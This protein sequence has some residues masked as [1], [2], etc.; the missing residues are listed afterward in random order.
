MLRSDLCDYSD[1]YVVVKELLKTINVEEDNKIGK[2][3]RSLLFKDNLPFICRISK[4]NNVL[5]DSAEDLDIAM[6]LC[7]LIEYS[8]NYR[9][10]TGSL[11][12]YYRDN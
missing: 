12:T 4:I 11:S 2:K 1:A 9:K 10:S 3:N 5:I 6:L 7:N 8:K